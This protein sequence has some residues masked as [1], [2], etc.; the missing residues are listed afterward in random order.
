[1]SSE[2]SKISSAP[3]AL[4][5]RKRVRG[6][7]TVEFLVAFVPL[8]LGWTCTWQLSRY[9]VGRLVFK[10]SAIVG[11]RAASVLS[12]KNENNP[13]PSAEDAKEED[14]EKAVKAAVGPWSSVLK[15][16]KVEVDDKSSKDDPYN[17]VR[18]KLTA[19]YKCGIPLAGRI[20]CGTSG[21]RT[22]KT[23]AELPHQG[24][25]YKYDKEKDDL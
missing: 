20:V 6:A 8:L 11:A 18:V 12:K 21:S 5:S 22:W 13:G 3:R 10:H 16:Q 2:L 7:F 4:R 25:L 15:I 23:E 19:K 1:M 17:L 9:F 24:A 14:I